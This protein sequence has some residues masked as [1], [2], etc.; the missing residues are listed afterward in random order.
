MTTDLRKVLKDQPNYVLSGH[1]HL[2][3]DQMVQGVRRINP[4]ALHRADAYTV[5]VLDLQ[6]DALRFLEVEA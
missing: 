6:S 2:A 5:A 3:C 4:G 1:S